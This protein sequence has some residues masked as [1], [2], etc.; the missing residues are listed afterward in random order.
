MTA[1]RD[2]AINLIQ[3]TYYDGID[4]GDMVRAASALAEDVDWS[5]A[6]VWAH[7]GFARAEPSG[8]SS[9]AEVQDFLSARVEQLAE[10]KIRHRI[11]TMVYEDGKGAFLG[12]VEG[13]GGETK[14]FFVWFEIADGKISRY[15]LRPL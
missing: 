5:H 6:Q 3:T 15:T 2:E 14:P 4:S 1:T 7:H 8:F 12:L 10:A 13:P 11:D 9:R